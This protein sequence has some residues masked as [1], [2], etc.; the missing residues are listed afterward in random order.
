[1][2]LQEEEPSWARIK[3]GCNEKALNKV[4]DKYQ[5]K[6]QLGFAGFGKYRK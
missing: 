4:L 5:D 1:M 3:D 2:R 6:V